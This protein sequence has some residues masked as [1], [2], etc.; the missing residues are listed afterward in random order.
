MRRPLKTGA[1]LL[2][3]LSTTLLS[4]A[5][6][7]S[8]NVTVTYTAF[9]NTL[10]VVG[11]ASNNTLTMTSQNGLLILAGSNGTRI[12]GATTWSINHT[13]P[14]TM[15]GNLGGG[16]DTMTIVNSTVNIPSLQL[17]PG[18]DTFIDNNSTINITTLDGGPGRDRFIMKGAGTLRI[19]T[20]IAMP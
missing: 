11:D 9:T 14:I 13:G 3:A 12:N 10:N 6:P 19:K 2:G 18:N 17:G 16:D 5:I 7:V 15:T 8:N 20:F 4:G 1:M